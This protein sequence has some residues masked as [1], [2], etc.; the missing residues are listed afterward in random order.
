MGLVRA[1]GRHDQR[2]GRRRMLQPAAWRSPDVDAYEVLTRCSARAVTGLPDDEQ[3]PRE[4][5][6]RA[7]SRFGSAVAQL[8][9]HAPIT[10]ARFQRGR[11]P[12]V[13]RAGDLPR[14][15][16]AGC[17]RGAPQAARRAP[18]RPPL[19]N[20]K[21][22][23]SPTTV[24]PITRVTATDPRVGPQSVQREA[25][26]RQLPSVRVGARATGGSTEVDMRAPLRVFG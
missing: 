9:R 26:G 1:A 17:R 20:R 24:A 13:R 3:G 5:T 7:A 10:P 15:S 21:A 8:L 4:A 25:G 11:N 23:L 16:D 6:V 18:R 14:P 2:A 12:G 19:F 22:R